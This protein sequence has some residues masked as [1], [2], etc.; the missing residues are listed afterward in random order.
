MKPSA[1]VCVILLALIGTHLAQED[2]DEE[3]ESTSQENATENTSQENATENTSQESSTDDASQETPAVDTSEE[4]STD[5]T[6]QESP[7]NGTSQETPTNATTQE[8]PANDTSQETPTNDTSSTTATVTN[9]TTVRPRTTTRKPWPKPVCDNRRMSNQERELILNMHNYYRGQLVRGQ[10][11]VNAGWGIA[12]PA[13]LMFR[14][15]YSCDAESYAEQG[16]YKCRQTKLP[17][18]AVGNHKQ[19]IRI[20]KSHNNRTQVIRNALSTWWTQLNRH[21]FRSNM[22]FFPKDRQRSLPIDSWTKMAWWNNIKVGCAMRLCGPVWVFTCMYNPGGNYDYG[23]VY[24]V[25][26][27]CSE[28]S[29]GCDEQFL[30]RW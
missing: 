11:Q 19:N 30:C 7:A 29:S 1:H 20:V 28:C 4:S 3:T 8:S 6:T 25:G 26:A 16:V 9:S 14:M 2:S 23:N 18:H 22:I 5:A 24:H 27:V 13:T 21:G 17:P 10:T 12:P 15:K